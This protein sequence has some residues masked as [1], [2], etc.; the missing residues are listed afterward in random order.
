MA[1]LVAIQIIT[2]LRA[3]KLQYSTTTTLP[4]KYKSKMQS[5]Q[6]AE[7]SLTTSI[8]LFD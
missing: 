7:Q 4:K 2:N 3:S 5:S 1:K 8:I 6:R